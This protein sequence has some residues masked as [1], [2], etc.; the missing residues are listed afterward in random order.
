MPADGTIA[1][2]SSCGEL[3]TSRFKTARENLTRVH[4]WAGSEIGHRHVVDPDYVKTDAL[5]GL[6]HPR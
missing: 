6:G 2:R 3:G 4:R 1:A 5:T